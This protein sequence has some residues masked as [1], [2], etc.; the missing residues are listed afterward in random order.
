MS[1]K[2]NLTRS[3]SNFFIENKNKNKNDYK[4]QNLTK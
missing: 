4:E 3:C 2:S 1:Q